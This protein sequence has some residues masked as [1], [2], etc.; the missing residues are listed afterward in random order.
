MVF[1]Y[2]Q[3]TVAVLVEAPA[4]VVI[5]HS[6]LEG[7]GFDSHCRPGSFLRLKSRP[8]MYGAVG[9]LA[10]SRILGLSSWVEFPLEPLDS[11]V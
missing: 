10:S 1:W 4:F 9:S 5:G 7:C 2:I 3:V 11:I 8:V 6:C